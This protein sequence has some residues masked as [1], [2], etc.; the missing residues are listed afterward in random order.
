MIVND[1]DIIVFRRWL[2]RQLRAWTMPLL[3][4]RGKFTY[5]THTH[6]HFSIILI[7][8]HNSNYYYRVQCTHTHT[9]TAMLLHTACLIEWKVLPH[10]QTFTSSVYV[11]SQLKLPW[12]NPRAPGGWLVV[13]ENTLLDLCQVVT[14][15]TI[16]PFNIGWYSNNILCSN[17]F[18]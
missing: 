9:H 1:F 10:Q 11:P 14:L 15:W 8:L 6:T 12:R 4:V 3:Y 5:H 13:H 18:S 2:R 16:H 7:E 17:Y